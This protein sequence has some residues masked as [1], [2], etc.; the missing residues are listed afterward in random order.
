MPHSRYEKRKRAVG[1]LFFFLR[2]R[3]AYANPPAPLMCTPKVG[4]LI[5]DIYMC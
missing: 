5:I 2:V 3:G 1:T 4:R